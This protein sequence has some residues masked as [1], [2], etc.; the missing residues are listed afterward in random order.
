MYLTCHMPRKSLFFLFLFSFFLFYHVWC[1][2]LPEN[3]K[4]MLGLISVQRHSGC[5]SVFLVRTEKSSRCHQRWNVPSHL[6]C[7][8]WL[9]LR[10]CS[11]FCSVVPLPP[12]AIVRQWHIIGASSALLS[13]FGLFLR[14]LWF[15]LSQKNNLLKPT[16]LGCFFLLLLSSLITVSPFFSVCLCAGTASS[17]PW[18]TWSYVRSHESTCLT[19]AC[20]L[21]ISQ[22]ELHKQHRSRFDV[23]LV[24]N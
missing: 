15:I 8:L 11:V 17:W 22:G 3:V 7:A 20:T 13:N 6:F 12:A 10:G 21:Q 16:T 4:I 18:A 14:T 19:T 9:R 2:R 23:L 1:C 5:C 24:F